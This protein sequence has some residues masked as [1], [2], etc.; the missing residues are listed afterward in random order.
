MGP[1]LARLADSLLAAV[2]TR[3]RLA[4]LELIEERERLL[5]RL[6]LL[7]AGVLLLALAALFGGLLI[8][9]ALWATHRVPAIVGTGLA[10]LLAGG[11][12]LWRASP[13]DRSGA[14]P[15]SATLAEFEKDRAA[16]SRYGEPIDRHEG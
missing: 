8:V 3:G 16:L 14:S 15:F 13:A 4:G 5:R 12:L 11:A 7:V 1:A 6:A 2:V 10:F 9:A